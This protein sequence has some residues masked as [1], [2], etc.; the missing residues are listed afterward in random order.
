MVCDQE[1]EALGIDRVQKEKIHP[2]KSYKMN[3]SCADLTL[4]S[5]YPWHYSQVSPAD[6]EDDTYEE[7]TTDKIWIDVQL[8]WGDYDSHDT[9]RYVRA[10]FLDFADVDNA[11][12][13][14]SHTGIMI[15]VDLAYNTYSAYGNWVPGLKRLVKAAMNK[16]M[17]ANP[18]LYVL[19]ER[20]RKALQLFSSEPTAPFL[21]A[22]NYTEMFGARRVLLVDDTNVYRVT[23][24]RTHEGNAHSKATNGAAMFLE[25]LTGRTY[26]KVIHTDVWK[27]Q[28]RKAQLSKWKTAEEVEAFLTALPVGE[29]PHEIVAT[30]K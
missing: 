2:R 5:A 24:H 25:P 18:G 23:V 16:I 22:Q 27:G 26:V 20:I 29:R 14:P 7:D 30:R 19:R 13:Y 8:R 15:A 21:N 12:L 6:T 1:V 3:S 28:K 10:R 4:Y 17:K 11:S 9:D